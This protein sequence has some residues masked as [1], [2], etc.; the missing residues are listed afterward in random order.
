MVLRMS[1]CIGQAGCTG[2]PNA[3]RGLCITCYSRHHYQQTLHIFPTMTERTRALAAQGL[4]P[5]FP[6][7]QPKSTSH[8]QAEANRR[9][10]R[11]KQA[12]RVLID[13]ALV[14]PT[15]SHGRLTSYNVYGCRGAMC[16]AAQRH[17]RQ[18]G[19][20]SLPNALRN[21][22]TMYDCLDYKSGTL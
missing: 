17:Y 5:N 7:F 18:T 13:G 22:Y 20:T 16:R 19:L 15:S 4:L 8:A 14:H 6:E 3:G 21:T 9:Y 12:E 2:S 1:H 10:Q 11:S